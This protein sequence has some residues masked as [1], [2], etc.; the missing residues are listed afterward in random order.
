[1]KEIEAFIKLSS[2]P[3]AKTIMTDGNGS[4]LNLLEEK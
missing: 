2:S 1:M 4:L 3:N